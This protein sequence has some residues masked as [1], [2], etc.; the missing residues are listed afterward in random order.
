VLPSFECSI[1]PNAR[2]LAQV[3]FYANGAG[4]RALPVNFALT[5]LPEVHMHEAAQRTVSLP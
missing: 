1:I 4:Q 2:A 5:E 3:Y